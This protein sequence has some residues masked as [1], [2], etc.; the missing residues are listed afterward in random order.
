MGDVVT[1]SAFCTDSLRYLNENPIDSSDFY[2]LNVSP[3]NGILVLTE[4]V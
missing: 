3:S 4:N 2:V 1:A